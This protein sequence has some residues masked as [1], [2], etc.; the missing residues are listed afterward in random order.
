MQFT[1]QAL[2]LSDFQAKIWTWNILNTK[3]KWNSLDR[4]VWH[5]CL[6]FVLIC[7]AVNTKLEARVC[8][9]NSSL[10]FKPLILLYENYTVNAVG[11]V[12]FLK[13]LD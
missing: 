11:Q 13:T 12:S 2:V 10:I 6:K 5:F 7:R 4:D 3:Q 8:P 9:A 1:I